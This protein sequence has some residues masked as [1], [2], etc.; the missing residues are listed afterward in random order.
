MGRA[1]IS[2]PGVVRVFGS[3]EW[4]RPGWLRYEMNKY[5]TKSLTNWLLSASPELK[6]EAKMNGLTVPI[7]IANGWRTDAAHKMDLT[8]GRRL[9][10]LAHQ[11]PDPPIRLI[12]QLLFQCNDFLPA[13]EAHLADTTLVTEKELVAN[14]DVDEVI[15]RAIRGSRL[16]STRGWNPEWRRYLT[17]IRVPALKRMFEVQ[18][19]MTV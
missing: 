1:T 7:I 16:R 8:S 3:T 9:I 6:S 13:I 5:Q 17:I 2:K 12:K 14:L 10:R 18:S 15:K 11:L 19:V 4:G